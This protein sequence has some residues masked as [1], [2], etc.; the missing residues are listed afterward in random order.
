MPRRGSARSSLSRHNSSV[1]RRQRAT[2]ER[3]VALQR[4][5]A[6]ERELEAERRARKAAQR[7]RDIAQRAADSL[8]GVV[9]ELQESI[10][11]QEADSRAAQWRVDGVRGGTDEGGGMNQRRS[12]VHSMLHAD[13]T[14]GI[15]SMAAS[16]GSRGST[17]GSGASDHG[18][19]LGGAPVEPARAPQSGGET[20]D[21][22]A[23]G[24][25]GD[26][27]E[28][29]G[30][31]L[32][33]DMDGGGDDDDG[34]GSLG[35]LRDFGLRAGSGAFSVFRAGSS[36]SLGGG[37]PR[38][39][40]GGHDGKKGLPEVREDD[41]PQVQGTRGLDDGVHDSDCDTVL[42]G[43]TAAT[44][45]RSELVAGSGGYG[46]ESREVVVRSGSGGGLAARSLGPTRLVSLA[47]RVCIMAPCL[48]LTGGIE[49]GAKAVVAA[50]RWPVQA[51]SAACNGAWVAATC[52]LSTVM[53]CSARGGGRAK[54]KRIKDD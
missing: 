18:H 45:H 49:S 34:A 4:L 11:R 38:G 36:S 51:G 7:S 27:E 44:G 39:T 26:N 14:P 54:V 16:H 5:E 30:A 47:L 15:D 46:G 23:R 22:R 50:V 33:K 6:V 31:D 12:S 41:E 3:D 9:G 19:Y 42:S 53:C 52:L 13:A 10:S 43:S 8:R 21:A 29:G 32:G 24:R 48:L 37:E 28:E 1:D 35:D 20:T 17:S 40:G 2:A 25:D